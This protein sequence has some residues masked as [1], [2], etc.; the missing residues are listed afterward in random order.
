MKNILILNYELKKN[1]LIDFLKTKN[2]KVYFSN[3]PL[4]LIKNLKFFELIISFN[5]TDNLE[6]KHIKMCRRP[7]L[8]LS[9]FYLPYYGE[10]SQIIW[11]FID[12]TP[13]GVTIHEIN[14]RFDKKNIIFQ[15]MIPFDLN[16]NKSLTLKQINRILKLEVQN[17][18]I[19]NFEKIINQK[20]TMYK[21]SKITTIK[22][23]RKFPN[24]LLKKSN[25]S[26]VNIRTNYFNDLLKKEKIRLDLISKIEN[27]R[28]TNNV[29]WMNLLKIAIKSDPDQTLEVLNKINSDDNKISK[30]IKKIH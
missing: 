15:K 17:L 24:Y 22:M 3:K 5:Q 19:E 8:N 25:N 28:K 16:K 14:K 23:T 12:N 30:L 29:N 4:K 2:F 21:P 18:L 7:I 9:T 11:S 10:T 1:N 27:T 6:E 26:I 20:Y 13:T